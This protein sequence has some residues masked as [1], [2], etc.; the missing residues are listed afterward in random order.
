MP[1]K[2]NSNENKQKF[3]RKSITFLAILL[4]F[5]ISGLI[6]PWK[7]YPLMPAQ[8]GIFLHPRATQFVSQAQILTKGVIY[9]SPWILFSPYA[10]TYGLHAGGCS[11]WCLESLGYGFQTFLLFFIYIFFLN[12]FVKDIYN[13]NKKGIKAKLVIL[14]VIW[15]A[16]VGV[17]VYRLKTN[18][19]N[20]YE[21]L[22]GTLA[23]LANLSKKDPFPPGTIYAGNYFPWALKYQNSQTKESYYFFI[24]GIYKGCANGVLT[25]LAKNVWSCAVSSPDGKQYFNYWE[26]FD[27]QGLGIWTSAYGTDRYLKNKIPTVLDYYLSDENRKF[28]PVNNR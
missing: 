22:N 19:I 28:T 4:F 18:I 8:Y 1:T 16:F 10:P 26:N 15:I 9:L 6:F 17:G 2:I 11:D 23:Q 24:G 13:Q 7:Y 27:N 20:P 14:G 3:P 21:E 25:Q 12:A 5:I